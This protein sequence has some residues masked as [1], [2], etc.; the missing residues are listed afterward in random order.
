MDLLIVRDHG[1]GGLNSHYDGKRRHTIQEPTRVPSPQISGFLW[2]R[3]MCIFLLKKIRIEAFTNSID[4]FSDIPLK[5]KKKYN[6]P[7]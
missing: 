3:I 6:T 5:K 7:K 2:V 4:E 1:I